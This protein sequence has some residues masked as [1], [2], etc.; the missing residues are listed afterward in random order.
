MATRRRRSL[1]ARRAG[2]ATRAAAVLAPDGRSRRGQPRRSRGRSERGGRLRRRRRSRAFIRKDDP[3]GAYRTLGESIYCSA[4][5]LALAARPDARPTP[6][7]PA[8]SWIHHTPVLWGRGTVFNEDF[9]AGDL[10]RVESL[11]RVSGVATGYRDSAGL[12]SAASRCAV[13]FAPR[14]APVAGYAPVGGRRA[15]GLGRARGAF[16]DIRLAGALAEAPG[17][18][19]R[20]FSAPAPRPRRG[21]RSRPAV[22]RRDGARGPAVRVVEQTAERLRLDSTRPDGRLALRAARLLAVP[23]RRRST[24]RPVEAVP[25]SSRSRAV[26]VPAGQ[27]RRRVGEGVP[28]GGVSRSGRISAGMAAAGL[29]VAGSRRT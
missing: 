20:R 18:A 9:D 22:A 4:S 25:A 8:D 16:P 26:P 7:P 11:R 5:R 21:R 19:R 6:S 15:A 12:S 23:R 28:G 3:E 27:H 24:A 10:S 17:A 14:P 1:C 29:L 2:R 13:A